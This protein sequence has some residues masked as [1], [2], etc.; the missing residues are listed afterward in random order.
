MSIAEAGTTALS[1]VMKPGIALTPAAGQLAA[2]G[3]K[4]DLFDLASRRLAWVDARQAVLSQNIANADTPQYVPREM[5]PFAKQLQSAIGVST[6]RTNPMH[7]A[8]S[9]ENS[10]LTPR[11]IPRGRAPDGNA[12]GLETQLS[13]VA[14]DETS[15]LLVSNLWKSYMG[16]FMTALGRTS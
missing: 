13:A 2:G 11:T 6:A 3:A 10:I 9:A 8:G 12:V 5:V 1:T 14:D 4:E 15:S 7:L 16:M